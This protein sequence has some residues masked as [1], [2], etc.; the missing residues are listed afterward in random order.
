MV[1]AVKIEDDGK[2]WEFTL[3]D[4][5]LFHDGEKVLA[6]DCV[7]SIRRWAARDAVAGIVMKVTDEL[8]APDDRTIRFRLKKPFPRLA[9][10][11]GKTSYPMCATMP[12]R[13]ANFD[14][15]KQ[16]GELDGSG[17]FRFKADER[18]SGSRAIY[19]KFDRYVPRPDGTRGSTTGP[20][21]VNFDRVECI[22]IPDE[23]TAAGA[24]QAGGMDWWEIP[25]DD[26]EPVLLN[27]GHVREARRDLGMCQSRAEPWR[28]RNTGEDHMRTIWVSGF[29]TGHATGLKL[30]FITR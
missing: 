23:G 3:R 7:A 14:P 10:A 9:Y 1:G 25:T 12:E 30:E 22:T 18:V 13:F 21:I 28:R 19:E 26:L 15:F 27:V 16:I 29:F 17:P 2:R 24:L 5:L 8:S 6:R 4:G 11:L 20:K